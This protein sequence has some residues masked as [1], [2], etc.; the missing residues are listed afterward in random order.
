MQ[1]PASSPATVGRVIRAVRKAQHVRQDDLGA[2]RGIS[3]VFVR[4]AERGKETA[5]I[6]KVFE[7]LSEL[8]VKVILDVPESVAEDVKRL[9]EAGK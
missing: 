3:H 6:G 9:L 7:L 4:E 2:F 5:Q 8:G 1:I